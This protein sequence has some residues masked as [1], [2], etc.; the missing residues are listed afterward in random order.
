VALDSRTLAGTVTLKD[1]AMAAYAAFVPIAGPVGGRVDALLKVGGTF[2]D[3]V[4]VTASGA[5]TARAFTLGPPASAPVKI[6]RLAASGIDVRWPERVR[7]DQVVIVR[8]SARIERERD[9][10]FP[11]RALLA[12]REQGPPA[13]ASAA[14]PSTARTETVAAPSGTPATPPLAIEIGTVTIEDGDV[15]FLDRSTTPFYSEE[16]TRLALTLRGLTNAAERRASLAAQAVVG[17]TGAL[18][19]T[20]EVAPFGQPF[21]VEVTGQLRELA[22]PRT[23]PYVSRFMDW[24]IGSGRLTTEFHYRISGDE[25]EATNDILVQ[26]LAVTRLPTGP[27]S[28]KKIG[29]PLGLAVSL[30]KDSHGDIRLSIPVGGKLSAPEFSFGEAIVSTLKNVLTKLIT[31]PFRAVGRLF[32]KGE[33][34]GEVR[35]EDLAIDPVVFQ[36]GTA[37]VTP[38]AEQQLQRVADFLR[39]SPAV[40]VNVRPVVSASDVQALRLGEVTARIQRLQREANVADFGAAAARLYQERLPDR[41]LPKATD[42]VL[43]ALQEA[44]PAP[45]AAARALAARRLEEARRVL[46]QSAGIEP[47]RLVA[48][49]DAAAVVDAPGAG[50]V[51]FQLVVPT[52]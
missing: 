30:L 11:L 42:E 20:G 38:E 24:V 27:D 40:A 25:L 1:A 10:T 4:A 26:R 22:L 28:D 41:Q 14:A 43:A 46:V 17:S 32:T 18:S 8:P 19:L 47:A 35:A 52:E 13:S 9:G 37:A 31:A 48:R 2:T 3:A 44:E 49:E 23:N 34:Q 15:R 39:A 6:E 7:V 21:F 12:P 33:E 36:P 29:V 50:R 51:E 45:D 16:V 5:A